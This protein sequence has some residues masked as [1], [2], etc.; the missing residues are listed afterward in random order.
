MNRYLLRYERSDPGT[1]L[2]SAFSLLRELTVFALLRRREARATATAV[3]LRTNR[4]AQEAQEGRS[5]CRPLD[6]PRQLLN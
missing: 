2:C 6:G 3:S 1:R 5:A 4:F